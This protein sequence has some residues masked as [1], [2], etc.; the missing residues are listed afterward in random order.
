MMPNL[1]AGQQY[2]STPVALR[3]CITAATHL[4]SAWIGMHL[5]A[6][7]VTATFEYMSEHAGEQEREGQLACRDVIHA[8]ALLMDSDVTAL[9][10]DYE[11]GR[12]RE[13]AAAD[14]THR[15]LILCAP[16][17][18][19]LQVSCHQRHLQKRPAK[20]LTQCTIV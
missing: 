18:N 19:I 10:E 2:G 15:L 20:Q 6:S 1:T 5:A 12:Q 14:C 8:I 4:L 9:T 7:V 11:V 13:A 16:C 3:P 17:Q